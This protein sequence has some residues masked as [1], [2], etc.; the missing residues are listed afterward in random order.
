VS[1]ILSPETTWRVHD[2]ARSELLIDG[3]AYYRAFHA[4]A[5]SARK[6]ILLLGWQFDSD[7]ELLRGEDLP[8]GKCRSDVMLVNVLHRLAR[9]RPGLVTRILAWDYS[10]FFAFEREILQKLYFDATTLPRAKVVFRW[11][12]TVPF[13]GSHHQKVAIVDGQIAFFGSQD[14]CQA[15]WDD[16]THRVDNAHRTVRGL[17]HQP[18]HEVQV[19]VTGETAR[20]LVDLFVTRWNGATGERLD[21]ESLI[22]DEDPA[23]RLDVP[24]AGPCDPGELAPTVPMPVAKLGLA[25]TVPAVIGRA[26]VQEVAALLVRAIGRAERLVYIESQYLTSCAVRDALISRMVDGSRPKLEIVIVIPRKP[27]RL[28]E[29]LTIGAPQALLLR[30][31]EA[32]SKKHGHALGVYNVLAGV[33]SDGEPIFVYVHSKLTIVDDE[34]LIVGSA[35]LTNRSLTIDSEI[36]AAYEAGPHDGE[37]R[38]A[39]RELRVRLLAEHAFGT[40][41]GTSL[42]SSDGLV[43]RLDAMAAAG[44]GRLRRYDLR[45]DEPGLIAKAVHGLTAEVLDP[46]DPG[47]A[48]PAA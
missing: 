33:G 39:I 10:M 4:A 46:W 16:S 36:V 44:E 19:A 32:A 3:R 9:E 7:V 47:D 14:I 40:P 11:D 18:Y 45:D 1:R 20:S 24:G 43:A 28:K 26:A 8:E 23:A 15:R 34:I 29:E 5:L 38:A 37:V 12:A 17:A 41:V 6:S 42:A 13:G 22:A 21:P 2:R 27:E 30:A 31:V 25:R 48:R 35:N